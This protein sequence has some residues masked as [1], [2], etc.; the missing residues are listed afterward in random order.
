MM[1]RFAEEMVIW[2]SDPFGFLRI[3]DEF[4]TGSSIMPQKR[5]PD[6]AELV[7]AKAGRLFGALQGLLVVMKGLPLAYGKDMQED[8]EP[9]FDAADTLRLCVAATTGMI[10]GARFDTARM[11]DAA[12]RG[13]P[14]ATDLADWLVRV[15]GLP[16]RR[17]HHVAGT[18]VKEAERR[19]CGLADLP[20]AAM[21]EVEPAID[22]GV[23]AV[24][25]IDDAVASR[26][27]EGGTAPANVRAACAEARARFLD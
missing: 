5:N 6:A 9:V 25:A 20:L 27:S 18:L 15:A 3:A 22:D 10:V 11:R 23:Y 19:G 2:C 26:T 13:F 4:S 7:R 1:S 12:E 8:K 24:L 21:R 17:A 14:T 16:F